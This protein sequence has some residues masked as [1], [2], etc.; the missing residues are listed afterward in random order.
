M[1]P[2]LRNGFWIIHNF[3]FH[4]IKKEKK[5]KRYK[6]DNVLTSLDTI[7]EKKNTPNF[8]TVC[9]WGKSFLIKV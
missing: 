5:T 7:L 3:L 4:L 6:N 9:I 2:N 1:T 8:V